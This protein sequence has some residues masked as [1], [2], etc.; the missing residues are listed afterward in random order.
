MAFNRQHFKFFRFRSPAYVEGAVDGA[1]WIFNSI[2]G[3]DFDSETL[4]QEIYVISQITNGGIA[5]RDLISMDFNDYEIVVK[6][7]KPIV[8]KMGQV[9]TNG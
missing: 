6:M 5:Y 4:L 3:I 2:E 8:E 7:T 1:G 9:N